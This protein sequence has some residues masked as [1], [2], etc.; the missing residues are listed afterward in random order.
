MGILGSTCKRRAAFGMFGLST[1]TGFRILIVADYLR[2]TP[3]DIRS[4]L[5]AMV[6][7]MRFVPDAY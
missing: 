3:D 7:S 4:E 6:D 5:L 1:S 2:E